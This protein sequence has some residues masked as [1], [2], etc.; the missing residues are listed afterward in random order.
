[1]RLIDHG[2]TDAAGFVR[3]VATEGEGDDVLLAGC[4]SSDC[5]QRIAPIPE[6]RDHIGRACVSFASCAAHS[7]SHGVFIRSQDTHPL[8]DS[9]RM[10]AD[11][12]DLTIDQEIINRRA[13]GQPAEIVEYSED[14]LS[15]RFALDGFRSRYADELSAQGDSSEDE[16]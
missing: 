8:L 11:S 6:L 10:S 5:T 12:L 15:W 13:A 16:R 9:F 2:I 7:R 4:K 1:M 3:V 14:I